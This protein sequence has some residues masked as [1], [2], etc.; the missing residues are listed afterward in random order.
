MREAPTP[1][2]CHAVRQRDLTARRCL[3]EA[4]GRR[5]RAELLPYPATLPVV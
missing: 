2:R 3:M 5:D 1:D 4:K